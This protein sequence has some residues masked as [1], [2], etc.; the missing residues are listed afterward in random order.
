MGSLSTIS[1]DIEQ[2]SRYRHSHWDFLSDCVNTLDQADKYIPIKKYP[3]EKEYLH[4]IS[5]QIVEE[6]LLALVK[7]RR[8]VI[9]WTVC[10]L[11]LWDCMFHEGRFNVL[12]SK[13]EEDSDDLVRRC[14]FIYDNIPKDKLWIKPVMEY[15][16][17]ELLF[18][19]IDSKI[20][21]FPQGADQLRQYTCSRVG[22]DEMA[23]WPMARA[24]FVAMK[25][26]LEGGGKVTLFSTRYPGFF[27][28]LVEDTLDG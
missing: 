26:T 9:T 25:P 27:K 10:A 14:K 2:L 20:K 5:D 4:Y 7:N 1:P 28:E 21:G 17:T 18:P 15:K 8:M 22:A 11:W 12:M 23:F 16:Y 13:K 19:E 6:S 24:S 3:S